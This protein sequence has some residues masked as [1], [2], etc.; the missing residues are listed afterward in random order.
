MSDNITTIAN[1]LDDL[2]KSFKLDRLKT[3]YAHYKILVDG[4]CTDDGNDGHDGN[5]EHEG[6]D[7]HDGNDE[8]EGH[9]GH[10]HDG[11]DSIIVGVNNNTIISIM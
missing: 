3:E 11:N 6:H 10:G 4:N 5:D 1:E 9:D 7:G 2:A 8:H